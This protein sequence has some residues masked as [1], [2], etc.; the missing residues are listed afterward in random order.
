MSYDNPRIKL[1][2]SMQDA[3][4]AMSD[5]NPGAMTA[6]MKLMEASPAIDPDN[7]MGVLGP[8]LS[9]DTLDCYGSRIWM[10]Y[11]DVCGEHAIKTLAVLRA[12]QLGIVSDAVVNHAID[13]YGEGIDVDDLTKQVQDRLPAFGQ[14]PED[15][16]DGVPLG[17]ISDTG[18]EIEPVKQSPIYTWRD[19]EYGPF[20]A[21][22]EDDGVYFVIH[23]L[24][25]DGRFLDGNVLAGETPER[26]REI[27]TIMYMSDRFEFIPSDMYH[28]R[29][30]L[31]HAGEALEDQ[32]GIVTT[33]RV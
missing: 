8:L 28:L 21:T 32:E 10:L 13:S 26:V 33:A 16:P 22:I 24:N 31:Y 1:E 27:V 14:A 29:V 19:S 30:A 25:E 4:F 5:G 7:A 11:K 6:L 15:A 23:D 17:N 18:S 20:A 3:L 9:L 12:K 2:M